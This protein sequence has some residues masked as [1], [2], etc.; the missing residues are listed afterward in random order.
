MQIV[1]IYPGRFQPF[2]KGHKAS[3][4]NLVQKFGGTVYIATSD[5]Q[6]PAT[7]PFS[8]ADRVAMITKSGIPAGKVAKVKNPY[9]AQEI[10][11]Q[12]PS[13]ED[14]ALIFAVSEKDMRGESAR[15]KFGKKKDGSDSYMQPMPK[16]IKQLQPLTK[17]AYVYVT[18]TVDF[19][20]GG[21]DANSATEIRK[22]YVKGNDA[23]RMGI[24][25][26]LYGDADKSLKDIFDARL[27]PAQQAREFAYAP[28]DVDGT[29]VLNPSVPVQREHK[30]KI[31]RMLETISLLERRAARAYAPLN[32]DLVPDYIPEHGGKNIRRPRQ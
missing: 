6:A 27:L 4:D 2:H 25:T 7:S 24:V 11:S 16:D 20:V 18:P 29:S 26:D 13:P 22:A 31:A 8:F 17:H 1:V 12:I 10:T 28:K 14:T 30:Q 23:D 32:E 3:Y 19:K 15:F 9:Q 5:V 21:A